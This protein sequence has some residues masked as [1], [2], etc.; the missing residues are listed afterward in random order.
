MGRLLLLGSLGTE[1]RGIAACCPTT[2]QFCTITFAGARQPRGRLPTV[3]L[4][5]LAQHVSV[6]PALLQ[7]PLLA[8]HMCA[9]LL[10]V[11]PPRVRP[12]ALLPP[13]EKL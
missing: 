8:L 12:L 3:P 9:V 4:Q 7:A 2:V 13:V 6:S 1:V 11:Q 10:H 5:Q